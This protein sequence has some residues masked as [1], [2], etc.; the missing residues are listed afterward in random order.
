MT[1]LEYISSSPELFMEFIQSIKEIQSNPDSEE[2]SEFIDWLSRWI[3][4]IRPKEVCPDQVW[5][6]LEAEEY[7]SSLSS[8]LNGKE[9]FTWSQINEEKIVLIK[10]V[11]DKETI[12]IRTLYKAYGFYDISEEN[13][14][15]HGIFLGMVQDLPEFNPLIKSLGF[16]A[17][18]SNNLESYGII[19]LNQLCSLNYESDLM[20]IYGIGE[21]SRLEII[22][23]LE[24]LSFKEEYNWIL[25]SNLIETYNSWLNKNS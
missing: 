22:Y 25:N 1:N 14:L 15:K 4:A 6:L 9:N 10:N 18:S 2:Y 12:Y 8:Y 17:R 3:K 16:S 7:F 24:K 13:L 19:G 23:K 5:I 20:N 21:L 11:L